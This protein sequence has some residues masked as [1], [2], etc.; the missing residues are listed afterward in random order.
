MRNTAERRQMIMEYISDHRVVTMQE[1]ANEFEICLRTA[2][3]DVSIL[4]CSHPIYTQQGG[5]GGVKAVDGW[6]LTHRYLHADQEELLRSLLT[7]LTPEKQKTME[8]ILIAFTKP[9]KEDKP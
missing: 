5:G 6:Y 3:A 9:G 8:Q 2:K 1:I 4:A 7:G